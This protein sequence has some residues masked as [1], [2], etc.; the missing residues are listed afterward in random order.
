MCKIKE[1]SQIY[2]SFIPVYEQQI[3]PQQERH[4]GRKRKINL[5]QSNCYC[6]DRINNQWN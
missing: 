1:A 2:L 3:M 5:I 6:T 4:W